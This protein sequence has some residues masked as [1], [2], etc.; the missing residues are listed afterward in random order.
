MCHSNCC[1]VEQTG[2]VMV[3]ILRV[4]IVCRVVI[5]GLHVSLVVIAKDVKAH[6]SILP[7]G[8]VTGGWVCYFRLSDQGQTVH[9]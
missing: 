6:V 9:D 2:I 4:C 8:C 7:W 1:V 5:V 3:G